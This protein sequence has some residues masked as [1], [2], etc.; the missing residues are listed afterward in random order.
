MQTLKSAAEDSKGIF[1]GGA[2]KAVNKDFCADD[3]VK[4]IRTVNEASSLCLLSEAGFRL[5]K[6]MSNNQEVWSKI[7]DVYRARLTLDM[8]LENLPVE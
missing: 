7:P 5:T 4:S 1:S 8:D 2:V 3:F 6:W